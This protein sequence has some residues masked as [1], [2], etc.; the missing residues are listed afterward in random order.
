MNIVLTNSSYLIALEVSNDQNHQLAQR[1]WQ[2]LDR[3]STELVITSFIF[4]EV[5]TFLNSRRLHSKA[6]QLGDLLL[7]SSYVRFLQVETMFFSE[8]WQYFKRHKDKDYSLTDC[9]SFVVMRN[10][11]ITTALTFDRHFE[12]AGF[13]RQP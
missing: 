5:T 1:H 12:Q 2:A 11:G 9:I 4:D 7:Q 10:L 6:V 3:H 8:A 13:I